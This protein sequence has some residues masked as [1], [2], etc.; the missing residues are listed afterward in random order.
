MH[1]GSPQP[2]AGSADAGGA[3]WNDPCDI[4]GSTSSTSTRRRA[5]MLRSWRVI[6]A[7]ALALVLSW[8]RPARAAAPAVT[9]QPKE[10]DFGEWPA[11]SEQ[12]PLLTI[13]LSNG[14]DAPLHLDHFVIPTGFELWNPPERPCQGFTGTG[15]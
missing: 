12:R 14:G 7:V 11:K 10:A 9:F 6:V 15:A 4:P 5:P 3:L 2:V 8:P 1:S 13:T